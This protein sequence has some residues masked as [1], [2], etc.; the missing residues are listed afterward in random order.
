MRP[1]QPVNILLVDDH[2][3]KLL[4]YESILADTGENLIKASS[5]REALEQ[6]LKNEFAVILV[7]VCMPDLD[8][9]ELASLIRGHPRYQKTAIIL[10]S[11]VLVEDVDRLKGYDSGAVDYVSVP[12]VPEILRAKV[13]VFADL[14]RKTRELETLNQELEHRV[15]ERTAE[16]EA[17]AALLRQSEERMRLALTAGGIQGW[18]WDIRKNEFTWVTPTRESKPACQSYGDFLQ[19]VHPEDRA[20]VQ[21]AFGRAIGKTG[22]Y[23]AEFRVRTGQEEQWWLGRG[24]LLR[25]ASGQPLS[26][27]GININITDRKRA[28]EERTLLLRNAQEAR[29]EAEKANQLKDEFLASVSHELRT[30]LNAITGWAHMLESGELDPA[31]QTKA[32]ETINRNALLQTRLISDLLDVS[33]IVSGKLRLDL[34]PVDLPAVIQ[35]ALDTIRPAAAAKNIDIN[36]TLNCQPKP[37]T[38]DPARLQQ[39]AW[40]LLSNAVKFTSPNGHVQVRLENGGTQAELV[41]QD[42]GP[43]IPHE[44]LPYIFDRFRQADSSSTRPHRGLGLGLTI[45]R[46]LVELHGGHILAMNQKEGSGAVFKV[47]LP[48]R[49]ASAG[50]VSGFAADRAVSPEDAMR[51]ESPSSLKGARVLIVDDEPDAREVLAMLLER[52]GADVMVAASAGDAYSILKREL[53]D[54]LVADIEMPGEDGYGLIR[55][56]RALPAERGGNTPALALTAYAS[57]SDRLKLLEAGFH[58]HLPKPV[59]PPELLAVISGLL[60]SSHR[61]RLGNVETEEATRPPRRARGT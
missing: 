37:F 43:G 48:L 53:P 5:G 47:V 11:S 33:R 34:H 36:V 27:A 1:K 23:A 61:G 46:H 29:Q 21:S 32:V 14:F 55:R 12:I 17:S 58:K 6:L 38:G 56:V 40:N 35:A 54:A 9:F 8:G 49:A 59:R 25:D 4:S 41:V 28:E 7:D 42:D 45:A 31:T 44:F 3:A 24:T 10:V 2:P 13:G 15:A 20:I 52:G 16:I 18:T 22:E 30:P 51:L 60:N 57:T 39:V 19:A 50:A 26:I